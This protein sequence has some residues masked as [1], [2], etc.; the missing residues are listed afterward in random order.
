[1]RPAA[2]DALHLLFATP[3]LVRRGAL[4]AQADSVL[5]PL[6]EA[7]RGLRSV[8]FL[9]GGKAYGIHTREGN[10]LPNPKKERDPR[11][12]HKNFYWKHED[13][14][15]EVQAKGGET[16]HTSQQYISDS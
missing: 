9:Q 11:V 7:A 8:Q 4:A 14:T 12:E 3:V 5:A 2:A 10:R 13:Y 6:S 16:T 15:A 1:M